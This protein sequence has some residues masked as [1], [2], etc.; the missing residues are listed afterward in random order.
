MLL[1]GFVPRRFSQFN[2][3]P[4]WMFFIFSVGFWL[5]EYPAMMIKYNA[6]DLVYDPHRYV[7]S[8]HDDHH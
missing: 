1:G 8:H 3:D 5:G 2:R 4:C 7:W 6:R